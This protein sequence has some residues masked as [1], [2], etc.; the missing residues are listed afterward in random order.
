MRRA[1][2]WQ[3]RRKMARC[4]CGTF[5]LGGRLP[6]MALARRSA[7]SSSAAVPPTS[8]PLRSMIQRRISS[9]LGCEPPS[10]VPRSHL[11]THRLRELRHVCCTTVSK[12]GK[13]IAE[14]NGGEE[15]SRGQRA[16]WGGGGNHAAQMMY[17]CICMPSCQVGC[18]CRYYIVRGLTVHIPAPPHSGMAWSRSSMWQAQRWRRTSAA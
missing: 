5:G 9:T 7:P 8:S 18:F 4:A 15:S 11:A 12:V 3:R 17:T 13:Q 16:G 10:P 1:P 14:S 6:S 2:A